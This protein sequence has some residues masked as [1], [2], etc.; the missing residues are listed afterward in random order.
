MLVFEK[1]ICEQEKN[2]KTVVTWNLV[3]YCRDLKAH[4]KT[5]G[6]HSTEHF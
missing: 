5:Q 2:T 1:F 6:L 3:R 4:D